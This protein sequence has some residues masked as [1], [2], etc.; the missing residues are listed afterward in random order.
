[1]ADFHAILTKFG[2]APRASAHLDVS[3]DTA[4][5]AGG[6]VDVQFDVFAADGRTLAQFTVRANANG[7]ASSELAPAPNNNLFG[8]SAGEPALVRART[9]SGG[10]GA[11]ATLH[12]RESANRLVVSVPPDRRSDGSAV[13]VGRDFTLNVGEIRGSAALLVANVAAVDVQ[14]DV[15]LGSGGA[16]GTGR[17]TNP[18]IQPNCTWRVDLQAGETNANLVLKATDDIIV[19][20]VIDDGRLNALTVVPTAT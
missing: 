8:I 2:N 11:T 18:R 5:L 16:P 6:P 7:F 3:F 17:F 14:A 10:F 13:H 4:A 15:F 19:Q 9:P 1:M 12:Q 20:L